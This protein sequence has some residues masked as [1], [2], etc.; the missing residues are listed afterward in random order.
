MDDGT[1]D[2]TTR[3][4]RYE[5]PAGHVT[6]WW[7]GGSG[8][9]FKTTAGTQVLIDPYLS[10]SV[11]GI[12]GQGRAFPPPIEPEQ[13]R[14]DLLIATHWHEDHLDPGTIPIIARHS[15]HT[16]FVM[17]PGAM[18]RALGWGVP[19]E[20]ITT[21]ST[22]QTIEI[23]GVRLTHVPARH[24]STVQGWETP[25]AMGVVIECA[26][27]RVYH[28]GDTEYDARLLQPGHA[29]FSALLVCINGSGGNMNAHEA[30]LLAWQL[31]PEAVVPIH[32]HL[33]AGSDDDAIRLPVLFAQTFHKL[34]GT[35]TV[36]SPKIG[37]PIDIR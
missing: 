4:A 21:L 9:M 16:R 37:T 32:H 3:I 23:P 29:R 25:D 17:S 18:S 33:W 2:L 10:N 13:A 34:G 15:P 14:P 24:E 1:L 31:D 7:L 11:Q 30:A 8:F 22:A 20:R 6:A 27:I 26:G 5:V 12:F 28:T 35:A 36:V 19:R